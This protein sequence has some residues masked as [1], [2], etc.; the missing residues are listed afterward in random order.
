M[1]DDEYRDVSRLCSCVKKED[2]QNIADLKES[3]GF[4][5]WKYNESKTM[6]WLEKKIERISARLKEKNFN[7]NNSAIASNY[8][9][10][11]K[12]D[13][14]DRK[15]YIYSTRWSFKLNE[16]MFQMYIEDMPSG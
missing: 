15:F 9:K 11:T 7:V 2:L 8:V 12:T 3:G 10:A 4:Q 5:A 6:A 1:H 14:P 13:V 16:L